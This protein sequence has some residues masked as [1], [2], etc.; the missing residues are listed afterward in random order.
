[1]KR[2][3]RIQLPTGFPQGALLRALAL[4]LPPEF[5]SRVAT[6]ELPPS[7]IRL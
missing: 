4:C 2:V 6:I 1:M 7:S 5:A 3:I